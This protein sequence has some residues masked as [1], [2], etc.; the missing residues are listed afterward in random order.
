MTPKEKRQLVKEHFLKHGHSFP[1]QGSI[2]DGWAFKITYTSSELASKHLWKLLHVAEHCKV[3][4]Q[5]KLKS[6]DKYRKE[7]LYI[8]MVQVLDNAIIN[9]KAA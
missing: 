7:R 6:S 8:I 9:R 5:V 2:R 1:T 4:V 3:R